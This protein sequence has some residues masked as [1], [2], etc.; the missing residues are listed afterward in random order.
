MGSINRGIPAHRLS[1]Q[2]I[3]GHTRTLCLALADAKIQG[4][5]GLIRDKKFIKDQI[6]TLKH[7]VVILAMSLISEVACLRLVTVLLLIVLLGLSFYVLYD[8][9]VRCRAIESKLTHEISEMSLLT[10]D[11][12]DT[13]NEDWKIVTHKSCFWFD[14][15]LL[16]KRTRD[17]FTLLLHF[18][19]RK[20]KVEF[21]YISLMIYHSSN[22][23]SCELG[24]PSNLFWPKIF[25]KQ[26]ILR[27]SEMFENISYI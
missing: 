21:R 14:L 11:D 25:G 3:L 9:L 22:N 19:W 1:H 17:S 15:N 12:S 16:L 10:T 26:S 27:I 6:F 2:Q 20:L 13:E 23:V 8:A 5:H 24:K 7:L 18:L 4:I